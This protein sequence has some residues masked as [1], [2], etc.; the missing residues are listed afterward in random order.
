MPHTSF[1]TWEPTAENDDDQPIFTDAVTPRRELTPKHEA[2]PLPLVIARDSAGVAISDLGRP[3][4]GPAH[5]LVP[6]GGDEPGFAQIF[7]NVGRRDGAR[8]GDFQRMLEASGLSPAD[9]GRVRVRDR[10]SFVSVKKE[11]LDRAV[12][13]FA[14]QVIGGRALV[15]EPARP[16]EAE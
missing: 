8:T 7:V 15:A 10:N 5:E 9:L 6:R 4:G 13:A 3:A 1:A 16:R 14:G 2:E 12:A 11:V